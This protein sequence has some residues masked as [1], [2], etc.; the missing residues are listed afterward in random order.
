M[1][2]QIYKF[3]NVSSF[4]NEKPTIEIDDSHPNWLAIFHDWKMGKNPTDSNEWKKGIFALT[5]RIDG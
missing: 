4:S 5:K 1:G 3:Q 2:Y